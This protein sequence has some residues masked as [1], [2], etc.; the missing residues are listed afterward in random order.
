VTR[1][2]ISHV[3][4]DAWAAELAGLPGDYAP[5]EGALLVASSDGPPVGCVALRRLGGTACEMKRMY[6]GGAGRGQGAGR[7]L[8]DAIVAAGRE[9]GYREMYLD[10]SIKQHEAIGLYRGMGFEEVPAYDDVPEEMR[11]WLVYFR[12][13]LEQGSGDAG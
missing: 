2:A 8:G 11:D 13:D 6:V 7:A 10:T 9:A 3:D 12:L 4:E 5:P 1:A